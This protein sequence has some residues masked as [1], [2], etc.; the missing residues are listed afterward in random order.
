MDHLAGDRPIVLMDCAARLL[1]YSVCCAARVLRYVGGI[2]ESAELQGCYAT[3]GDY[4]I[5]SYKGCC[6]T[7]GYCV[8]GGCVA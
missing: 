2:T 6:I 5:C 7:G 4:R 1:H 8:T 3:W